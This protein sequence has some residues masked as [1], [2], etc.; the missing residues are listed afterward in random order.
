MWL[1]NDKTLH[2]KPFFL[3][4]AFL[5][6]FPLKKTSE[7][8]LGGGPDGVSRARMVWAD[9]RG[10][11]G[12]KSPKQELMSIIVLGKNKPHLKSHRIPKQLQR[13]LFHTM[14]EGRRGRGWCRAERSIQ[15]STKHWLQLPHIQLQIKCSVLRIWLIFVIPIYHCTKKVPT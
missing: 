3:P 10:S 9:Q 1:I 6:G 2:D 13:H 5:Y 8:R 14:M 15:A 7:R 4:P 12:R 11:G